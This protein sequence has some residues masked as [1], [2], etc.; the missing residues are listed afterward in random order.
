MVNG[1][2][3]LER[4]TSAPPETGWHWRRWYAAYRDGR[5]DAEYRPL[6]LTPEAAAELAAQGIVEEE[7]RVRQLL[8]GGGD[9]RHA[10]PHSSA[11]EIPT[12]E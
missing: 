6:V 5:I 12:P 4:N 9:P 10:A 2:A 11:P 8:T 7:S 1:G 3:A